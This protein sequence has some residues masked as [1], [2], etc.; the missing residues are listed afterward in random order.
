MRHARGQ[1]LERLVPVLL[2][3]RAQHAHREE[4]DDVGGRGDA[5]G[6]VRGVQCAR[7]QRVQPAQQIVEHVKRGILL[8]LYDGVYRG[9]HRAKQRVQ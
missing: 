6:V 2:H 8:R 3:A 4:V 9:F 7:V 5:G 1:R